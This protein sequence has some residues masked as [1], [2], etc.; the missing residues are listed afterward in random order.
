MTKADIWF[1]GQ[2]VPHEEAN[3]HVLTHALHYGT[4]VFEGIRCYKT[5]KGSAIFRHPEHMQRLID[6]GR[7]Y[8]MDLGY[9]REEL[10]QAVIDTIVR[11]GM[12][13]CYIRPLSF[14]GSGPMGVNPYNNPVETIVAV[15]EWG[16]YLGPEALEYGV[17]VHV[18]S[19]SR[20]APNTFPS[21]AKAGGNYLNAGLVKMD[22]VLNGFSEGIMLS[23][24]GHVAEGSG[25]N[26]FL[27]KNGTMYTAPVSL[28]ILPGITRDSIMTLARDMGLSVQ[29]GLI[30]REALYVAD[31]VF[32]T[33]TAAEVTPV[34]S[35]DHH[36]IGEGRRGEITGRM[37]AAYFDIVHHGNDP[38]GWLTHIPVGEAS[39]G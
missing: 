28:S 3:V 25:E 5:D 26:L 27:V 12:E 34:R 14:R 30:P 18:A 2:F 13:A 1:N 7:I 35:I 22:A 20:M 29:E 39:T 38:Y 32:F 9:T 36:V 31:E 15:W 8:R 10:E 19:W 37:Q 21:M 16:A 17:D 24:N 33:G 11:S 4:S 23:T 6:S